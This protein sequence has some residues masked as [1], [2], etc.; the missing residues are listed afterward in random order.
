MYWNECYAAEGRLRNV[1]YLFLTFLMVNTNSLN[2]V[3]NFF[4]LAIR[5]LHF[6]ELIWWLWKN[7]FLSMTRHEALPQ[8]E[9][10]LFSLIYEYD[11]NDDDD[12]VGG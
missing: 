9:A 4:L 1:T 6:F 8:W 3:S 5:N 11:D 10:P 7:W 2:V 12:E